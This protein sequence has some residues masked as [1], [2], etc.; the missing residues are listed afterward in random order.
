MRV[1][2]LFF[3]LLVEL[4][5]WPSRA[6]AGGGLEDALLRHPKVAECGVIGAPDEERGQVVKA[7]VVLRPGNEP[8]PE[9]ARELQDYVKQS[10]APYK[11]PRQVEFVASLPR[12]ET[13]KLQRFRLRQATQGETK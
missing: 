4:L 12:T 13:G 11:D 7:I 8:T 1:N 5:F 10:I 3:L 9:T 2:M 6:A